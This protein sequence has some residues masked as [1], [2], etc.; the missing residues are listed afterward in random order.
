[1]TTQP[2]IIKKIM[3]KE[4][5]NCE[6]AIVTR[7]GDDNSRH[8]EGYALVFDSWSKDLGGFTERISRN[9][10]DGVLAS[11]DV[12]ALLNHQQERGVLARWRGEKGSMNLEI[13][14][15]GLRYEFEAPNTALGDELLEGLRRGD[16]SQSSFAFS[17]GDEEWSKDEDGNYHRTINRIERLYDVSPVYNPAYDATSVNARG[18]EILKEQEKRDEEEAEA[19]KKAQLNAY[20]DELIAK[21]EKYEK[22]N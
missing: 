8:V 11:S 2:I 19:K 7:S 20:Y 6:H 21:I 4:I 15:I 1:M 16:I 18:L 3:M 13:D 14:D 17:V 9:A 5:R 22:P 10:L 12:L